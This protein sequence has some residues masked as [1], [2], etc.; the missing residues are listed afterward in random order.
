MVF[1]QDK[2]DFLFKAT[3][4]HGIQS[5]FVPTYFVFWCLVDHNAFIMVVENHYNLV[6]FCT[7]ELF[8]YYISL[9]MSCK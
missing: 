1:N 7:I 5:W 4:S 9:H 2:Q 8:T 6:I 3:K